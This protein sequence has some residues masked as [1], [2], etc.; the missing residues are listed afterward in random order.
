VVGKCICGSV[1]FKVRGDMPALY[2]CFCTLCQKQ[3]G[4]ASNAATIVYSE[5]FQWCTGEDK[6][7]KWHKDT[8]FSSHFCGHCG[9]PVPN[10]FKTKFV[11]IPVGLMEQVSPLVK[12]NIWL[13][14]KPDWAN[15]AKLERNYDSAPE[16]I[17]EFVQYLNTGE[18][19]DTSDLN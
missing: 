17:A 2:H 12:A 14:A 3:G 7:Q 11:W 6:I 16:D 1:S 18:S 15:P 8:G 13:S 10:I 5:K 4:T 19:A 9:S